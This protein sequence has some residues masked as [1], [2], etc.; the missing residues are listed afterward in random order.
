MRAVVQVEPG[1]LE[2]NYMWLPTAIGLNAIIKQEMERE[3]TE[4]LKGLV[5]DEQGLDRA[6]DTVVAFLEKKFPD[7]LGLGRF[8]DAMKYIELR[9]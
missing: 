9:R 2:V 5:L 4:S 1:V 8:L 7:V 3:L 6:H